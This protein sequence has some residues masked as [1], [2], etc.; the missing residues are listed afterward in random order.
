LTKLL[1]YAILKYQGKGLLID[2]SWILT[3][4]NALLGKE[5][6]MQIAE[7]LA[8]AFPGIDFV[9]ADSWVKVY[10]GSQY[11]VMYTLGCLG[12]E[13]FTPGPQ[14]VEKGQVKKIFVQVVANDLTLTYKS[15]AFGWGV[16]MPQQITVSEDELF[17]HFKKLIQKYVV[18]ENM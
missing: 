11:N 18:N 16:N 9:D 12:V 6:K 7:S 8:K 3:P 17:L 1:R 4:P 5:E 2:F 14:V 10:N 13:E 15:G